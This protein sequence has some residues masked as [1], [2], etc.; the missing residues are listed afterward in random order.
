MKQQHFANIDTTVLSQGAKA[1][2]S[3]SADVI[4]AVGCTVNF[5]ARA[6]ARPVVLQGRTFVCG[7]AFLTAIY[8][9]NLHNL[10]P[11][12]PNTKRNDDDMERSDTPL[13]IEMAIK[14]DFRLCQ[15]VRL[16]QTGRQM[17]PTLPGAL[18]AVLKSHHVVPCFVSRILL[19]LEQQSVVPSPFETSGY[20]AVG[21]P[22][23]GRLQ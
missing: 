5:T 14:S 23:E 20:M 4:E 12:Y 1:S 15:V 8:S 21:N 2:E 7:R 22:L 6:V 11:K 9:L 19:C 16:V 17:Q 18:S 3:V 10:L 13:L